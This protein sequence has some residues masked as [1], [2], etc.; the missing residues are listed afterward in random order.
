MRTFSCALVKDLRWLRR[1]WQGIARK[2]ATRLWLFLGV[3]IGGVAVSLLQSISQNY[4]LSDGWRNAAA[5][6]SEPW[7]WL[8]LSFV[9]AMLTRQVTER[10]LVR[11]RNAALA[12]ESEIQRQLNAA[13]S[14]LASDRKPD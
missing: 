3:A 11:E 8:L 13:R 1:G 7:A 9:A 4:D 2:E 12:E 10:E 5:L 6:V 14:I